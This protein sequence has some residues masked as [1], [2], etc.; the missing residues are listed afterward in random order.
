MARIADRQM[1]SV[2]AR[3]KRRV[4]GEGNENQWAFQEAALLAVAPAFRQALWLQ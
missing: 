1:C 3:V 2:A 4:L